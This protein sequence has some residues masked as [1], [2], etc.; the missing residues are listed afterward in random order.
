MV[1]VIDDVV[2]VPDVLV[3][4]ELRVVKSESFGLETMHESMPVV[5]QPIS[6]V[7]PELTLLGFA[8]RMIDGTATCT[9]HCAP[10]VMPLSL[11]V[12]V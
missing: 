9:L 2:A 11:Q 6:D 5:S 10:P 12:S 1:A 3:L 4:E 7:P 8:T